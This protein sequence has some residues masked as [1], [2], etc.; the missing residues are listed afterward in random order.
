MELGPAK[1]G[2]NDHPSQMPGA[3]VEP[4]FVTNPVEAQVASSAAG[5]KVIAAGL[6]QGLVAF[7]AATP[8]ATASPAGG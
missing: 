5:Q 2:W 7:L 8:G 1:P 3:L 6:E 4:F